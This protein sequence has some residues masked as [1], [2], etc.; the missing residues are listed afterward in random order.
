MEIETRFAGSTNDKGSGFSWQHRGADK[1]G[2]EALG[3]I[4]FHGLHRIPP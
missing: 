4:M 3:F 2:L 1:Q